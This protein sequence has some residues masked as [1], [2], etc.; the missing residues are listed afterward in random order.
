MEAPK[1]K[2]TVSVGRTPAAQEITQMNHTA[3][4]LTVP[5]ADQYFEELRVLAVSL[6]LSLHR[7]QSLSPEFGGEI[8]ILSKPKSIT[9]FQS[10]S[11]VESWLSNGKWLRH[12]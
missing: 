10:L 9:T 5:A 12:G 2:A 1:G 7:Q 3:C 6:H 8:F 4:T 11:E